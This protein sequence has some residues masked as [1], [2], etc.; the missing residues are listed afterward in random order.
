MSTQEQRS[1]QMFPVLD[2]ARVE[3]VLRFA[4]GPERRR[5]YRF[6]GRALILPRDDGECLMIANLVRATNGREY[7]VDHVVKLKTTS[8]TP[9]LSPAHVFATLLEVRTK[10]GAPTIKSTV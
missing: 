2:A 10:S 8:I 1:Y 5:G 4:S 7:P 9:L 3:T 6:K